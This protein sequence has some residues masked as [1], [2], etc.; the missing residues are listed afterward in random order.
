MKVKEKTNLNQKDLI[1]LNVFQHQV[2]I[3]HQILFQLE[4]K[5]NHIK[6]FVKKFKFKIES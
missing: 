5:K 4:L 3:Y 1:Q 2:V 6:N